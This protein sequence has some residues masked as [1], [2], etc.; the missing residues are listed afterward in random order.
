M[1]ATLSVIA[2]L[3]LIACAAA[4]PYF[5]GPCHKPQKW[6][7]KVTTKMPHETMDVS[8]IPTNWDWRNANGKNMVTVTRFVPFFRFI[9]SPAASIFFLSWLRSR[10]VVFFAD[11][12]VVFLLQKSTPPSILRV[13]MSFLLDMGRFERIGRLR[14][15]NA[16][17]FVLFLSWNSDSWALKLFFS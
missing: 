15:P 10:C 14:S 2:L 8:A 1:R 3:G 6:T 13:R 12:P 11:S 4:S 9:A 7:P 17:V 16:K 5:S